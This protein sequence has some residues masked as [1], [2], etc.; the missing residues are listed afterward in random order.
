LLR[1]GGVIAPEKRGTGLT[2]LPQ[3]RDKPSEALRTLPGCE[4]VTTMKVGVV[5]EIKDQEYR[6][7]L[8]PAGAMV[9]HQAGHT[10]L[11]QAGAGLG[12]GFSD[13]PYR[14]AGAHIVA[15]DQA[16]DADLVLKVKEPL[17]SEYPFL[18]EI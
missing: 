5:E 7:A 13:A 8:T 1:E 9:L 16:W 12:S 2:P 4:G 6:V 3:E 10:I 15:V 18:R 14:D 17:A 11:V